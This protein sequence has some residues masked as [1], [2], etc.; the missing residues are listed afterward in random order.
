[1]RK[2]N[3]RQRRSNLGLRKCAECGGKWGCWDHAGRWAIASA[4]KAR[5]HDR[6]IV[7]GKRQVKK[8][9]SIPCPHEDPYLEVY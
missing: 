3:S 6:L 4:R 8:C 1:M 7:R 9:F 5:L 2:I